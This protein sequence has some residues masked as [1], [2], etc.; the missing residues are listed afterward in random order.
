MKQFLCI[1]LGHQ[2]YSPDVLEAKPWDD[3]DFYGYDRLDFRELH[4]LR[5]GEEL[6]REAA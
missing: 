3:P 6:Q 4:C 1:V 2:E 5:C